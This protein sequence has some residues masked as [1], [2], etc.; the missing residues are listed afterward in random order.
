MA[1][2][3]SIQFAIRRNR[4]LQKGCRWLKRFHAKPGN[5]LQRIE[6]IEGSKL[7]LDQRRRK[8]KKLKKQ[9]A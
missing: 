5:K 8:H 1:Q 4:K 2:I 3:Q 7:T 6:E 9:A